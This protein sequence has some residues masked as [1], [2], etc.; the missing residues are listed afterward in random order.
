MSLIRPKFLERVLMCVV[1]GLFQLFRCFWERSETGRERGETKGGR[2]EEEREEG[3]REKER[4][5]VRDS[6]EREE[7]KGGV[8]RER[9]ERGEAGGESERLKAFKILSFKQGKRNKNSK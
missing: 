8:R 5:E 7:R 3:R 1:G 4:K 9:R 2:E 6:R